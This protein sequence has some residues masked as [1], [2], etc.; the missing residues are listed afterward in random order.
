MKYYSKNF[1]KWQVAK[2]V[3]TKCNVGLEGDGKPN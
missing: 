2:K 1:G 3:I